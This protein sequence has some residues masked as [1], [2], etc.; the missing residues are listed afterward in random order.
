MA[1]RDPNE[2]SGNQFC[3][4][5]G[6]VVAPGANVCG[7]CGEA[8]QPESASHELGGDYIPYCRACG[9]PVAREAALQCPQCGM[10][11]LCHEHYYPSSRTCSLCPLIESTQTGEQESPSPDTRPHGPLALPNGPGGRPAASVLCPQCGARI[12]GGVGYCP[13]CG[14]EQPGAGEDVQYAGFLIR[15]GAFIIDSLIT[16]VPA[17]I[18]TSFTDIPALGTALSVV[19]YVMFTYAKGQTPGKMLLGLHVVD[20]NGLR[21]SLKQVFLREVI[22]KAISALALLIGFLWII[23][24]PKKRGWHDYIGGTY[25]IKR[26]RQ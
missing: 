4:N 20:A 7:Q 22:G 17:A 2:F 13:N 9:A 6:A 3:G 10:M 16:G 23:W 1:E 5:C 25:V 18:I 12:G 19:Y 8:I 15:L 11:P 26:G 21:P 14:A 24:D